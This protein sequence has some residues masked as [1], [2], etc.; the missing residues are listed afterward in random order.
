[1]LIKNRENLNKNC[2]YKQKDKKS[3]TKKLNNNKKLM[4]Q[5]TKNINPKLNQIFLI[6]FSMD[7]KTIK[8]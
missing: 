8:N 2:K 1:M 6:I 4:N 7:F 5:K 3:Y